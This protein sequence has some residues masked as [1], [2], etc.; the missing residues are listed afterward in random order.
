MRRAE[1]AIEF[2]GP[3]RAMIE[4][5]EMCSMALPEPTRKLLDRTAAL[6]YPDR[7]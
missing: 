5:A 2:G 1:F 3:A 6:S 7:T 4:S